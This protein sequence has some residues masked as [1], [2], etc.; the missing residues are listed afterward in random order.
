MPKTISALEA[1]NRLGALIGWAVAQRDEV[2][3]E[4]H[5][6]PHAVIMAYAEYEHLRALRDQAR[7]Q[8]ALA[9]LEQLQ[10]TVGQRNADLTDEAALA[11]ADTAVREAVDTMVREGRVRF[12]APK[13]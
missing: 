12:Q 2:I 5:G 3:V 1:K 9:R 8:E 7:R 4:R 10:A 11:L 13:P 6:K